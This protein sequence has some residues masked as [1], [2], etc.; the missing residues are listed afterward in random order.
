MFFAVLRAEGIATLS[1]VDRAM[2]R[3][4]GDGSKPWLAVIED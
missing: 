1:K 3:P 2:F 4:L